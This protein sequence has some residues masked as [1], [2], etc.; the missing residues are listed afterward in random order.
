M[1]FA[2]ETTT[3][4]SS[5]TKADAFVNVWVKRAD[6]TRAKL[7]ALPLK[8]SASYQA[9]VIARLKSGGDEAIKALMSVL[10]IDFKEA[11][12]EPVAADSVGF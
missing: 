6:G 9:G 2:K 11:H 4:T 5:T 3:V 7:G 1:A 10:E 12:S 8:N